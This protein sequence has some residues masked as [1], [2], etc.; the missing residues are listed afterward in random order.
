MDDLDREELNLLREAVS[1]MYGGINE[2]YDSVKSLMKFYE[3][4]PERA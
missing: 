3:K 4:H 1:D 2:Y